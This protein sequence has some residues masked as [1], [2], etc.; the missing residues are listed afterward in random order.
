MDQQQ[1]YH[2]LAGA[3]DAT[4]ALMAFAEERRTPD[5]PNILLMLPMFRTRMRVAIVAE[6]GRR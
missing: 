6:H 5:R 2:T 3:A 4:R 1:F